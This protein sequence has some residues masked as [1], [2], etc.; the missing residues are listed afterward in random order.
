MEVS[1]NGYETEKKWIELEAGGDEKISIRLKSVAIVQQDRGMTNAIGMKFVYIKPS[2]FIMGSPPDESGRESDEK[3]HKVTLT[4]GF[5]M[6]TTEVTQGQWE[7]VMGNNPSCF[8]N[9]G[10]DCP[11]EQV[12]WNDAQEFIRNLNR[13]EGGGKIPFTNRGGMGVCMSGG[14]YWPILL[15]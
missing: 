3:Q 12:S 7:A 1:S 2:T 13:K 8:N 14:E 9:C 11:V 10:D 6:Q 4:K 5:Y 15:W